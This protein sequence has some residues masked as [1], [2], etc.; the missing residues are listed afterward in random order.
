MIEAGF[1]EQPM[2]YN[3]MNVQYIKYRV[4]ILYK[5]RRGH[6]VGIN[7]PFILQQKIYLSQT[8]G[9]NHYFVYVAHAL[10]KSIYSGPFE[11]KN[12]MN[13]SINF[14]GYY[15]ISLLGSLYK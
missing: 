12:V 10:H 4:C 11:N 7:V 6:G 13:C 8:C 14:N 2:L 9:E 15:H 3:P 1:S 5:E